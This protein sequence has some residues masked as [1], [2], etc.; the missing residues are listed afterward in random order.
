M[1]Q[2]IWSGTV[3]FGLV[4]IPVRL[5]S[6]VHERRAHFRQF[7]QPDA[8]RIRYRRVCERD[9]EEVANEEIVRGYEVSRDRFVLITDE[10]LQGLEPG[11]SRTIDIDQFIEIAGVD[12]IYYDAT[13]YLV[14]DEG[15]DR[16][17]RLLLQAMRDAGKAAIGTFV[18]RDKEHVVTIR[19]SGEAL[20]LQTLVFEAE[21]IH[22]EDLEGLPTE[23]P[24]RR[25]LQ[26]AR[27]IVDG[28]AGAFD[29]GQYQDRFTERVED[30]AHKKARG[31]EP[32]PSEQAEEPARVVDLMDA[33]QKSVEQAESRRGGRQRSS[34]RGRRTHKSA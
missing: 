32:V 23:K 3:S 4:T 27:Q 25:E 15:G 5:E 6:A 20:V 10:E 26:M 34:S 17:Y 18:L 16:S 28:M 7:H 11:R 31:Q 19:P 29:P 14:P 30:L 8:G 1:P 33:L 22:Q 24:D 21:V 12:P 9:G 13:Y 2:T